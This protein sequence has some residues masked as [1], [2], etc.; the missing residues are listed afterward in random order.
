MKW[1]VCKVMLSI[2]LEDD[3]FVVV[4]S[5]KSCHANFTYLKS[6]L[7]TIEIAEVVSALALFS[8]AAGGTTYT[9][10]LSGGSDFN[11][12]YENENFL[13]KPVKL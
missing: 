11:G 13:K 3:V 7:G 1:G 2:I 4:V 6:L 12:N 10:L 9:R 5:C 8:S